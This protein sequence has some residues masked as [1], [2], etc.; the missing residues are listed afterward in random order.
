M[1]ETAL[2]TSRWTTCRTLAAAWLIV[3]C[4]A[5]PAA[6]QFRVMGPVA[7]GGAYD[8]PFVELTMLDNGRELGPTAQRKTFLLDTGANGILAVGGAASDLA[9]QGNFNVGTFDEIGVGGATTYR[10]SAPYTAKIDGTNSITLDNVRILS[11]PLTNFG[12]QVPFEGIVGMP[13]MV[14]RVTSLDM[15][16]TSGGGSLDGVDLTDIDALIAALSNSFSGIGVSFHDSVPASNG[17][18]VGVPV[19][20]LHFDSEQGGPNPSYAPLAVTTAEMYANCQTASKDNYIIDTGAQLSFISLDV[21]RSLGLNPDE[22]F[23]QLTIAGVGGTRTV[24]TFL[25]DELRVPTTD[26]SDLVWYGAEVVGLDLDPSI[27]GVIGSDLLTAGMIEVDFSAINLDDMFKIGQ[28]PIRNVHFDFRDL[29]RPAQDGVGTMYLDLSEQADTLIVPGDANMDGKV[30]QADLNVLL[31]NW[32]QAFPKQIDDQVFFGQ[33]VADF[34][35]D[36]HVDITDLTMMAQYWQ[37][38][39]GLSAAPLNVEA[40]LATIPEP[41]TAWLGLAG[42]VSLIWGQRRCARH[43]ANGGRRGYNLST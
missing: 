31:G 4:C 19:R 34:N 12:E 33:E 23:G 26:G 11:D 20:A 2:K 28:G 6:A 5:A 29:D 16:A 9:S 8:Q 22:P 21:V 1:T 32:G 38:G 37:H 36:C 43:R 10:V 7:F 41:S 18:R 14:N 40:V 35:Y 24:P 42:M 39:T 27:D 25:I 15:S 30:T 3:G 13:A 17:H